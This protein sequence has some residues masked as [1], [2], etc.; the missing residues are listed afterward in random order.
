MSIRVTND[1]IR[2]YSC[3]NISCLFVS[4]CDSCLFVS[5]L[6]SSYGMM[7]FRVWFVSVRVSTFVS[8]R[9][10]TSI[11]VFSCRSC[12]DFRVY[13]CLNVYS[14][15]FVSC[16]FVSIRDAFRVLSIRVSIVL[17]RVV[18]V[19]VP[20]WVQSCLV[21]SG[22]FVRV[23]S[24]DPIRVHSCYKTCPTIRKLQQPL[25][26]PQLQAPRHATDKGPKNIVTRVTRMI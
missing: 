21:D 9:V 22:Q 4:R 25:K 14:C 24:C 12:L 7:E 1:K 6:S 10:S 15:L 8:I 2:V 5:R 19:R 11:R 16:L 3:L 23:Y 18:S 20:G 17:F 13:S 26:L